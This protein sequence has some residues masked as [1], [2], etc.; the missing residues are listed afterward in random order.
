[1]KGTLH[2]LS[3]N[4]SVGS[5][6]YD[7][8]KDEISLSY[9]EAW[10]FGAESFPVSLSLPL[11]RKRHSDVS[12][13]PFLQGLL[14]DNPAVIEAWGKRF[15]VSPRNPFDV[16][17]HVG[18]DCA[19]ALQFVR[20]E[21][22]DLILSGALDSLTPLSEDDLAMRMTDLKSQSHAVPAQIEGRFS[23]AGAQTKDALFLKEGQWF[24]PGGRIPSTHIL[25][26][27]LEDFEEHALNEHF[28]LQLAATIGLLRAESSILEIAGKKV[29]CV[30]R[31]D[32][33][34]NP[35]GTIT[36]WHQED[37][38]Q[39]LGFYPNQKYQA[40]GGPSAA[41]IVRLLDQFSDDRD[42]DISRFIMALALNWVI[43]GTDAH[44][45]N[46]SLLH[47]EASILRLAPLYDVASF[48]P[49]QRDLGSTKV[50]L[51]MKIGG[52]YRLHQIE[53]T[54]WNKWAEEAGLSPDRVQAAVKAL[55][56]GIIESLETTRSVVAET[57]DSPFVHKLVDA[58]AER[59]RKCAALI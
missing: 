48:L 26:P 8:T 1:M 7:R 18:E 55:V 19:G 41:Q 57:N 37:T 34:E 4:V 58:I 6:V 21:R 32:R 28:C 22:L 59:A 3:G 54:H 31:Y 30:K 15:Q 33:V 39:A 27:Q 29:L 35:S 49:Y 5:L 42:D 23:L 13:R 12:I 56:H 40:D 36:R 46:Y 14:P 38:C 43:A 45:K 11:T 44:S 17:K 50:K 2:I 25:K 9:E 10:Q 51:A 47:A 24:V 52:T 16:I 53:A 20:P